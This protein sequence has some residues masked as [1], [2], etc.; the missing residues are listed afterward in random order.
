MPFV[1]SHR[2]IFHTDCFIDDVSKNSPGWPGAFD[3]VKRPQDQSITVGGGRDK[4]RVRDVREAWRAERASEAGC[5]MPH[6]A[7]E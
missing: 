5:P 3:V 6:G 7:I 4:A 2:E 1:P